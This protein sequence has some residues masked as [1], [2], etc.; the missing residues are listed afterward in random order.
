LSTFLIQFEFGYVDIEHDQRTLSYLQGYLCIYKFSAI[1]KILKS[2]RRSKAPL[3]VTSHLGPMQSRTTSTFF[4]ALASERLGLGWLR[5]SNG[6][7]SCFDEPEQE[8]SIMHA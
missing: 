4:L 6:I 3:A 2:A 1:L 5:T 8:F 7:A